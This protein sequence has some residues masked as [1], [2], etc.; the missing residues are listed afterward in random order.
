MKARYEASAEIDAPP[1]V[2]WAHLREVGCWDD[3][4]DM[5]VGARRLDAG[6]LAVGSRM[7]LH[8]QRM[9]ASEWTLEELVDG[10]R[11]LW[12]RSELGVRITLAYEVVPLGEARCRVIITTH[13][14]GLLVGAATRS[15]RSL[16]P[17]QL[18]VEAEQ[19]KKRFEWMV[20]PAV[21]PRSRNGS[22]AGAETPRR[23]RQRSP[24]D[25]EAR[26]GLRQA[27][28]S[29]IEE[30]VA[31]AQTREIVHCSEWLGY[32]PYGAYQWI[33]CDGRD[34]QD[35]PPLWEERDLEALEAEGFLEKLDAWVN[36]EDD[37]HTRTTYRVAS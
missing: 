24:E 13:F 19:L 29:R 25:A 7:W 35:L 22:S 11:M 15:M 10:R 1:A 12:A 17:D 33:E 8:R 2:A 21:S 32:L 5:V 30:V 26:A 27:L 31:T 34:V 3:W 37:F 6:P 16:L 20:K 28:R 4:T 14:S 9:K 23:A 18:Q 36:P